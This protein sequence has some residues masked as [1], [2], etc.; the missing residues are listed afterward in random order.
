MI[1]GIVSAQRVV[2]PQTN[3]AQSILSN[4]RGWWDFEENNTFLVFSD[5]HS[6]ARNLTTTATQTSLNS[7]PSGLVGRCITVVASPQYSAYAT[8]ART[9]G[10]FPDNGSFTI[11]GWHR[12]SSA[13]ALP[14]AGAVRTMCSRYDTTGNNRAIALVELGDGSASNI[15]VNI[16][17]NGTSITT[18]TGPAYNRSSN[19][20][21]F[22]AFGFD[23][24]NNIC[25]LTVDGSS[26]TT[27]HSGGIYTASTALFAVGSRVNSSAA[28]SVFK[29]GLY[30]SFGVMGGVITTPQ[31]NLLY[32]SGSGLN[33]AGLV[34]LG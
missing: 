29:T 22:I 34:A 3:I 21:V 20:W 24:V 4:L 30:D 16:S 1:P 11:F 28:A 5:S 14:G 31:Y 26:Y 27:A 9:A 18:V 19:A 8:S 33:Y 17:S 32:N 25:F 15:A 13:D 7:S 6:A 12:T 23:A 10:L 2:A